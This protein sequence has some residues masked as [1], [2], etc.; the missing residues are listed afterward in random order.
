[1]QLSSPVDVLTFIAGVRDC[2]E[3]VA[4]LAHFCTPAGLTA[5][6]SLAASTVGRVLAARQLCLAAL[7][8]SLSP[9]NCFTIY[10]FAEAVCIAPLCQASERLCLSCMPK[11]EP[12]AAAEM[13]EQG[14]T[15]LRPEQLQHLLQSEGL[16]VS[17]EMEVFRAISA[18]VGA[19]PQERA[20]VMGELVRACM[21]LGA[22][23]LR[24]LEALDQE[25]QVVASS[26]VTRV[27]AQAYVMRI[28]GCV[29]AGP[30]MRPSVARAMA[31][32]ARIGEAAGAGVGMVGVAEAQP[33]E[34]EE[35]A[36][37]GEGL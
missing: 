5:L 31:K 8:A 14:F 10:R 15:E 17:S 18:W 13:D 24:Q 25:P 19:R 22:M 29:P 6:E 3:L 16:Q 32:E 23:D 20:P 21:R 9:A 2:A 36:W 28:M 34:Y 7:E 33:E 35:M 30:R 12:E 4:G 37:E 26:D 1:M 27:V 11:G